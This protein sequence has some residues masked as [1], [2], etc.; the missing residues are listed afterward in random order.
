LGLTELLGHCWENCVSYFG[1]G[2]VNHD[3]AY[4][5]FDK[6]KL[7]NHLLAKCEAGGVARHQSKATNIEHDREHSI[8]TTATGEIFRARVVIDDSGH[9]PRF[10]KRQ[11]QGAVAYQTAYGIVGHFSAPPVEPQQF[12]LQDFRSEHLSAAERANEPPTFLY[13]ADLGE[14]VYFVEETSLAIAPPMSFEMLERRLHQR[15]AA[16][17]IKVTA[18]HEVE[19]CIFPMTL[20]LPDLHQPIVAFGGAASMVHPATGLYGRRVTAPRSWISHSDCHRPT[21]SS[22]RDS[23]DRP[24]G[25]AGSMESRSLT[26]ILSLSVWVR[27]VNALR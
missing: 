10:V 19:R 13:A 7:Q 15:L 26:Q 17:G 22:S 25:L 9:D 8:V 16:R 3:R 14:G 4:G 18:V 23:G 27:E 12:V 20:P 6:V 1:K 21:R 24:C 5:L 2:E 11:Q